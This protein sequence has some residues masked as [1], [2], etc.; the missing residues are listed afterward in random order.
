MIL[1]WNLREKWNY[2]SKQA[3]IHLPISICPSTMPFVLIAIFCYNNPREIRHPNIVNIFGICTSSPDHTMG[4]PRFRGRH[5]IVLE[6]IPKGNLFTLL[7]KQSNVVWDWQR[8]L[9]IAKDIARGVYFLHTCPSGRIIHRDLK[10]QNILVGNY[11]SFSS[12][13]SIV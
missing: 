3:S 12:P 4:D 6:F 8:R 9:S 5:C 11:P 10:S 13:L 1:S 2:S 7:H